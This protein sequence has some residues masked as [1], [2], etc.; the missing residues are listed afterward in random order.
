MKRQPCARQAKDIGV[1]A[2]FA[3]PV[4]SER[5]VVRVLEFFCVD[6]AAPDEKILELMALIGNQLGRVFE[7]NQAGR[8]LRESEERYRQIINEASGIIYRSDVAGRFT[9]VNHAAAKIIKRPAEEL[10]GSQ[11]A[12]LIH[13]DYRSFIRYC[14]DG[15]PDAGDGRL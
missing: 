14:A 5:K 6:G 9:F 7:R 15:L 8:N 12:E 3:F 2:A 10:V 11:Y 13:P 4:L 1:K